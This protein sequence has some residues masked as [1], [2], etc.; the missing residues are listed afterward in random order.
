[1][2]RFVLVSMLIFLVSPPPAFADRFDTIATQIIRLE[3]GHESINTTLGQLRTSLDLEQPNPPVVEP[4]V[5]VSLISSV[6]ATLQ[7]MASLSTRG[8]LPAGFDA[9]R[10]RMARYQS[11]L[12]LASLGENSPAVHDGLLNFLLFCIENQPQ[13]LPLIL[14]DIQFHA[15]NIFKDSTI[16]MIAN[17]HSHKIREVAI[18]AMELVEAWLEQDSSRRA[19]LEQEGLLEAILDS[20]MQNMI[21]FAKEYN[22][23]MARGSYWMGRAP[24]IRNLHDRA[25]RVFL[26]VH[27]QL[28]E[29]HRNLDIY[30]ALVARWNGH[31]VG[32]LPV[33]TVSELM[34]ELTTAQAGGDT[35]AAEHFVRQIL[36]A[37]K[38]SLSV[39]RQLVDLR[40]RLQINQALAEQLDA[41]IKRWLSLEM[42]TALD[43]PGGVNRCLN[44]LERMADGT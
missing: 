15:L 44:A 20:S 34:V 9:D 25:R 39:M 42:K 40:P 22:H 33:D 36:G 31:P 4:E 37:S 19:L 11:A 18:R 2:L 16:Q 17:L 41:K 29:C 28:P 26:Q 12:I 5:R 27:A 24:R 23:H 30:S 35:K 8:Y 1:M 3:R 13:S 43:S 38:P 32:E 10:I 21:Y 6:G 14:Q 7:N